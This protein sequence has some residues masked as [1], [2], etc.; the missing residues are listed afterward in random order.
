MLLNNHFSTLLYVDAL[1]H[2]L[3][4]KATTTEVVPGFRP[5]TVDFRLQPFDTSSLAINEVQVEGS[6]VGI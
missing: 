3:S 4:N 2:G 6:D 1:S 5:L